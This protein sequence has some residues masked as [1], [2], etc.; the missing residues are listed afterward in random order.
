[1]KIL[2]NSSRGRISHKH[3]SLEAVRVLFGRR[4]IAFR[5]EFAALGVGTPFGPLGAKGALFLSQAF[6]W[7]EA[8]ADENGYFTKTQ[9]EIFAVTGL[10]DEEQMTVRRDFQKRGYIEEKIFGREV[11]DPDGKRFI[12]PGRLHYKL[13]LEAIHAHL[14]I[15]VTVYPMWVTTGDT[16][17]EEASERRERRNL[18]DRARRQKARV[19]REKLESLG[20]VETHVSDKTGYAFSESQIPEKSQMRIR[21]PRKHTSDISGNTHPVSPEVLFIEVVKETTGQR[22]NE[23][24]A[25]KNA[26]ESALPVVVSSNSSTHSN[27]SQTAP[28][29]GNFDALISRLRSAGVS[30]ND[31]AVFARERPEI[32]ERQLSYFLFRA[33]KK[34]PGGMLADSIRLDWNPPGAYLDAQKD[35]HRVEEAR[36]AQEQRGAAEARQNAEEAVKN[37]VL[38]R[39]R[40]KLDT[41]WAD[42]TEEER[43]LAQKTALKLAEGESEFLLDRIRKTKEI[44]TILLYETLEHLLAEELIGEDTPAQEPAGA[45]DAAPP[46]P[47]LDNETLDKMFEVLP[48]RARAFIEE[49]ARARYEG[50]PAT[51]ATERAFLSMR[52]NLIRDFLNASNSPQTQLQTPRIEREDVPQTR[53]KT[54]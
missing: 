51:L 16:P 29:T 22:Q 30:P 4:A 50:M 42:L 15:Q 3:I 17:A 44:P 28:A 48:E 12:G 24:I 10:T 2:P 31:A 9:K 54:A 18:L 46:E 1:M 52:R 14:E 33:P 5:P 21:E 47:M 35:A 11:I 38:R 39:R 25:P 43:D 34:N 32:A 40:A 36:L 6:Y 8:D 7:A 49:Q 23:A 20:T 37:E 19:N 27:A 45:P 41:V 26:P 53:R 13:G